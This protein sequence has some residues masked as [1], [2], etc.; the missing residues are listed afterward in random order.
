MDFITNTSIIPDEG[1]TV[2][3]DSFSTKPG[4]KGANQAIAAARL[5][6][7]VRMIGCVGNDV[8]RKEIIDRFI[9][10]GVFFENAEPVTQISTG[11]ANITVFRGDNRI[12]VIPGANKQLTPDKILAKKEC[13]ATSD[14]ILLQLEIPFETVETAIH[15]A[16]QYGV[17]VILNPAPATFLPESLLSK[18]SYITP[19]EFELSKI[20]E[21]G[22]KSDESMENLIREI[23]TSCIV[24][25]GGDGVYYLND[26]DLVHVPG[27]DVDVV[28][29]TGAGDAFNGAFAVAIGSG[30]SLEKAC[31]FANVVGALTVQKNGAQPGMPTLQDIN[32]FLKEQ[33]VEVPILQDGEPI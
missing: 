31:E 7:Q 20:L 32:Q 23:G 1:V 11:V 5:G 27:F 9:D 19:N 33:G 22:T 26:Y 21:R 3:G 14:V 12:I 16:D 30:Y 25:K 6:A 13:I 2:F 4:G 8:F 15:L 29:T 17:K 10:E 18:V 24:T 28:D